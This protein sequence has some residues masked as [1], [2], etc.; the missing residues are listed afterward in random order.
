MN[1]NIK[2][3]SNRNYLQNYK[4]SISFVFV[5]YKSLMKDKLINPK[6]VLCASDWE[7]QL[8]STDIIFLEKNSSQ[9][10]Q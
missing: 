10:Q 2:K 1:T 4:Q 8:C 7:Y 9:L 5:L 3:D 6:H